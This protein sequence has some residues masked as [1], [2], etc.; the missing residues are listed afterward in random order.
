MLLN[1]IAISCYPSRAFS[2]GHCPA[3][4]RGRRA[5]AYGLYGTARYAAR[6]PYAKELNELA[7][8]APAKHETC[9]N[10]ANEKNFRR[11]A[12]FMVECMKK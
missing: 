10:Q 7:V 12:R 11:E 6:D 9:F 4:A 1:R 8:K 2:V 5:W 3:V